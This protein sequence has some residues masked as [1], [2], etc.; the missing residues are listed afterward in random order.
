MGYAYRD[1]ESNECVIVPLSKRPTERCQSIV[2][3]AGSRGYD[4]VRGW[5]VASS[6]GTN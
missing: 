2:E 6:Y 4:A 3:L 5:A 1:I